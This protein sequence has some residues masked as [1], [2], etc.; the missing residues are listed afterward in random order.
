M[1]AFG[2][3]RTRFKKP[4]QIAV[5]TALRLPA[6]WDLLVIAPV[7][8]LLIGE[9]LTTSAVVDALRPHLVEPLSTVDGHDTLNLPC[10]GTVVLSDVEGLVRADQQRL[11]TWLTDHR[12]RLITTSRGSLFPM[13]AAG[14]FIESLYYRL[15]TVCIDLTGER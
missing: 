2:F 15:N 4:T 3:H 10:V 11:N 5:E 8:V 12:S 14:M 6:D 7:N 13:I 1:P 9:P